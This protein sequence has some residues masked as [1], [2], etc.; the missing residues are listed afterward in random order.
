MK[1]SVVG[2]GYVGLSNALVLAQK[3]E[4][5]AYDILPDKIDLLSNGVFPFAFFLKFLAVLSID[6]ASDLVK[7]FTLR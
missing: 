6:N 4:V 1:I 2:L 5:Y 3:N 7:S